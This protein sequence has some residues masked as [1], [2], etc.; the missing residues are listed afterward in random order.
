MI[1]ATLHLTTAQKF[2]HVTAYFAQP[3]SKPGRRTTNSGDNRDQQSIDSGRL[4]H[5]GADLVPRKFT[6]DAKNL[7]VVPPVNEFCE[8]L[9]LLLA[10]MVISNL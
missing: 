8:L 2:H 5:A 7:H 10:S 1:I 3:R 9:T 6:P 4:E